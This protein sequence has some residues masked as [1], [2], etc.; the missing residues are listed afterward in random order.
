MRIPADNTTTAVLPLSGNITGWIDTF[1]DRDWY[2][3]SLR[4]NQVVTIDMEGTGTGDGTFTDP[5]LRLWDPTGLVLLERND[6]KDS[7]LNSQIVFSVHGNATYFVSAG[8]F[9]GTHQGSYTLTAFASDSQDD[10]DHPGNTKTDVTLVFNIPV[11]STIAPSGDED[12]FRLPLSAGQ[13]IR[14]DLDGLETAFGPLDV[15]LRLCDPS[16]TQ[17]LEQNDNREA[18]TKESRIDFTIAE[19]WRPNMY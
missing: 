3:L 4:E 15:A 1:G 11:S 7:T 9:L 18:G 6:D 5:Y 2:R 19:S 12:W 16:G 13:G 14:I 10:D 17:L 8:V